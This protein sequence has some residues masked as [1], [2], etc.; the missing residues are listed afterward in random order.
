MASNTSQPIDD[1]PEGYVVCTHDG[2]KYL[3]PKFMHE[4]TQQSLDAHQKRLDLG[5]HTAP[6]GSGN[7]V[8]IP[9]ELLGGKLMI[10]PDPPLTQREL[11]G[12]HA[13]VKALQERLGISYKDASHRLYM[14]E[15]E[16]LKAD[17]TMHKM[18]ATIKGQM[19]QSL[20]LFKNA[21]ADADTDADA[22]AGGQN[23]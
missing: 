20:Y 14:T 22:D 1:I 19:Q 8:S 15:I 23:S 6:G 21:D 13:E 16:K 12:L 5:V 10:P 7:G 11:L 17:E 9:Y 18:S 4:A 3:V 2:Q